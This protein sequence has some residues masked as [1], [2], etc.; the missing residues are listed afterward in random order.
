MNTITGR[1]ALITGASRGLG[2]E[3]ARLLA[4]RGYPLI[5]TA[6]GAE[7]LQAAADE[8]R[9]HTE[10]VVLAG[11]VADPAHAARLV[12]QGL[13]R[14]GRI[15]VLINNASSIGPSPMPTLETYPL[16]TLADVFAVNT[17]A[18]LHLIQLVLPQMRARNDGVIVN[19]TSDAAVQA[20]PT[21]GGYGASKAALE[22]LSRVLAAELE[23]TGIRVYVVDPG[24]MNTQMHRDAEPGVDLSHL[25][26]PEVSA[27]AFVRLIESKTTPFGRFEAQAPEPALAAGR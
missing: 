4:S 6:R 8:L 12:R 1:V 2:R 17:L 18:P 5:L 3:I 10:V 11:D 21:W 20:Y 25:P 7:A 15:D 9:R 13:H 14:F 26:G 27:P 24:D 19:V 23:G 22:H 16:D